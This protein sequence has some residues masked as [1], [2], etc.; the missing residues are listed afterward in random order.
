M[1][2]LPR[3]IRRCPRNED[4]FEVRFMKTCFTYDSR[5]DAEEAQRR[6][7]RRS[8]MM[9]RGEL[10]VPSTVE[11]LPLWL[12]SGGVRASGRQSIQ[13]KQATQS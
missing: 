2:V 8:G 13:A 10:P 9:K 7:K 3:G 4:R 5:E 11:N 1:A 12:I 6:A